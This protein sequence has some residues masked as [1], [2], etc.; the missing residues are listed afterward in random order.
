MPL[1][2]NN[3]SPKP[4]EYQTYI[5][6]MDHSQKPAARLTPSQR[7][8]LEKFPAHRATYQESF[9]RLLTTHTTKFLGLK[10]K[11][12]LWAI[13]PASSYGKHVRIGTIDTRIWPECE[14]FTDKGMSPVLERWKGNV[15]MERH[16]APLHA[17][18]SSSVLDLLAKDSSQLVLWET[19]TAEATASDVLAGMDQAIADAIASLS[20]IEKG[21]V[22]C[23][24]V[25]LC[26]AICSNSTLD[27]EE[28]AGKVVNSTSID[29]L[30]QMKEVQRACAYAGIFQSD[31]ITLDPG[32]YSTPAQFS[33][34][35]LVLQTS[36]E[37]SLKQYVRRENDANVQSMRK[38]QMRAILR[39]NQWSCSQ[40]RTDLNYPLFV[41]MF[42]RGSSTVTAKNLQ[43]GMSIK[44]ESRTLPF[45]SKYQKQVFVVSVEIENDAQYG[46][47]RWTDQHDHIV[48]SPIVA[49]SG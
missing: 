7:S 14:S 45:T 6:H 24:A 37:T 9:G 49:I 25:N 28:V 13:W 29:V 38:Q 34:P 10:L 32:Q 2:A 12:G 30:G 15:R 46:Y 40:N 48:S 4:E 31:S 20:V 11:T 33:I 39:R 43:Q 22:I 19:S 42:H 16:S 23:A 3:A 36:S 41:A 21:I 17:T 18:G 44:V 1:V 5:I 47:L 27:L 26:K 35:S 8:E